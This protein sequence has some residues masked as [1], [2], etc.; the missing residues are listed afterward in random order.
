MLPAG[1]GQQ[2]LQQVVEC[3]L[4]LWAA[5]GR[6]ARLA[7]PLLK[8]ADAL[9]SQGGLHL[10]QDPVVGEPPRCTTL[11]HSSSYTICWPGLLVQLEN[12]CLL[13]HVLP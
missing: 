3:L 9:F 12:S 7:T 6:G 10:L 8:C 2:R 13:C 1:P 11:C 4:P 5:Q